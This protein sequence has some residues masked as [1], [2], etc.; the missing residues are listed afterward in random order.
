MLAA[1]FLGFNIGVFFFAFW[2][3]LFFQVSTLATI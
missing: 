3:W 2:F 1:I